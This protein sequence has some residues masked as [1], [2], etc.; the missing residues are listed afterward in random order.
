[1]ITNIKVS[2]LRN[3]E[4]LEFINEQAKIFGKYQ[5]DDT[6]VQSYLDEWLGLQEEEKRAIAVENGNVLSGQVSQA[7]QYRD[8]LH[9][10]LYCYV[11]S[12]LYDE[13]ESELYEAAGR[14][15]RIIRQV[16]NPTQLTDSA[17]TSKLQQ[18]EDELRPY[19][20]DLERL[21][22]TGRLD[23]L[24]AANK[25]FAELSSTRREDNLSRPSGNVKQVRLKIDP[26]FRSI[27][28]AIDFLAKKDAARYGSLVT[29]INAVI[30][31]YNK[32]LANRSSRKKGDG[33]TEERT[34]GGTVK[35]ING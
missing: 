32:T 13:Q 20:A 12:F 19:S 34:N 2:S 6:L 35:R 4:H 16:G 23:K 9:G 31:D 28:G 21:D 33:G 15:M 22:A 29:E 24:I 1:M 3:N 14:V 26:L 25:R 18:L 11:K 10:C 30:A 17:E 27:T 7:E 5:F 8:R